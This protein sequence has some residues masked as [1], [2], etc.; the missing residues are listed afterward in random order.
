MPRSIDD[1]ALDA[2]GKP[3]KPPRQDMPV[4]PPRPRES[5]VDWPALAQKMERAKSSLFAAI[6]G[7]TLMVIGVLAMIDGAYSIFVMGS[8]IVLDPAM[9]GGPAIAGGLLGAALAV[10]FG[11][12]TALLGAIAF[13]IGFLVVAAGND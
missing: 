2:V 10:L 9:S 7:F 6:A 1:L 5:Q 12:L 8:Q 3:P 4:A 13:G 11:K